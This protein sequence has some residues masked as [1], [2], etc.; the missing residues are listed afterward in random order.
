MMHTAFRGWN[1]PAKPFRTVEI[2]AFLALATIALAWYNSEAVMTREVFHSVL[3]G[4]LE[5][6][7]V[8][9]QY[10]LVRRWSA[11]GYTVTPVLLGVQVAFVALLMQ[12]GLLLTGADTSFIALFRLVICA[13]IPLLLAAG[14]RS[15]WLAQLP[16]TSITKASLFAVPGSLAWVTLAQSQAET[17]L[18]A[19]LNSFN[20]AELA[21]CVIVTLGLVRVARLAPRRATLF[22]G[23]VWIAMEL[24]S[25]AG[26]VV[27]TNGL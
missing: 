1:E 4:Q 9:A 13:R 23:A 12:L 7:R 8:D 11:V 18:Y 26:R 17:P 22:T 10:D 5:A 21:W 15:L 2:F 25:F 27:I 14:G 20:V 3:G 16:A 19:L 6:A 24:F